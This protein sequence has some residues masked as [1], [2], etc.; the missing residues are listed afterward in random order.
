MA[1]A[2]K[3]TVSRAKV[4]AK[5]QAKIQPKAKPASSANAAWSQSSAKLYPFAQINSQSAE[6]VT[7]ASQAATKQMQ[8]AAEQMMKYSS[9]FMQQMF[10][11][12][13]NSSSMNM[14][15]QPV[16]AKSSREAADQFSKGS[17]NATKSI[18][19]AVEL[20]RE[21]S[22]VLVECSNIAASVSKQMSAEIT[23][24]LNK[25]FTQN[26]ELSKQLLA[27]RT[28]NDMFDLQNKFIKSNLDAFF[29]ESVKLSEMLFQCMS[30]VSEPLNERVSETTERLSKAF[31]A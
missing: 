9:D 16:A 19:D 14:G 1:T 27:C 3:K 18:N 2:K 30:D 22:E 15:F 25:T 7:Q 29:T 20:G 11:G 21:N 6:Q 26:N 17:A 28:L 24:Y 4:Q 13:G 31:A 8:D 5:P 23:N 12:A 10:S